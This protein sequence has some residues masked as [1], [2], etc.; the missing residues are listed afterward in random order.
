VISGFALYVQHITTNAE[1]TTRGSFEG[2]TAVR[3]K[4]QRTK[5]STFVAVVYGERERR[6]AHTKATNAEVVDNMAQWQRELAGS[7]TYVGD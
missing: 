5:T 3:I 4:N 6:T 7:V 1:R 2:G